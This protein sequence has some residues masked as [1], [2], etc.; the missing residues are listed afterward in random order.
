[1]LFL[2]AVIAEAVATEGVWRSEALRIG[3]C[4]GDGA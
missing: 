1:L 3:C 2:L 4:L